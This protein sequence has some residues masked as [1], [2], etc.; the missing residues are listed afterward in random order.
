MELRMASWKS[1]LAVFQHRA[2][3]LVLVALQCAITGCGKSGQNAEAAAGPRAIPVKVM[4]VQAE[5]VPDATDYLATLKSRAA[6]AL[7]PQ[8]EGQITKIFVRSGDKVEAGASII[9]IDPLKQQAAVSNQEANLKSKQATLEL[10]RVE[11]DRRK[12]LYS[13][14]V[15]SR[16]DL[17]QAQTA[18]E[19]AKADSEALQAGIREQKV[20]LHY[21][22][23]NAPT[24]GTIG[25]IP[26]HIGDRVTTQTLITTLDRGGALEAYVYVPAEKSTAVRLG[27]PVEI[28]DEAGKPLQR[29]RIDFISPQ[30]DTGTQTLLLKAAVPNRVQGLR[31]DQQVHVRLIWSEQKKPVIP[32]TAVS[33]LS[34]KIFA[35]VAEEQ[36]QQV[37]AH[38]KVIQVG[39][40]VG[41]DYVV[42]DG[43]KPGERLI[44]GNVQLL[45][46]GMAVIPQS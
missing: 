30:I 10:D 28:L 24:S 21:Y 17:D 20:Q 34:G 29:L 2:F 8:V 18:F 27:M 42:L 40:L 39:D 12:K 36:G 38:Q 25:D 14:G 37:V 41:N 32:V 3:V 19:A 22:T 4:A 15:I 43:L 26:V 5:L 35:F 44:V 6:S 33:R 31:N 46:D 45:V 1:R 11:L 23:V 7:Q 13:A 9:E 16:A